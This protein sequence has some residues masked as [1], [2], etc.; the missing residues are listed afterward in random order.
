MEAIYSMYIASIYIYLYV[1]C[2]LHTCVE[3]TLAMTSGDNWEAESY[4]DYL[5]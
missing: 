5:I 1:L 3:R 4:R 2:V